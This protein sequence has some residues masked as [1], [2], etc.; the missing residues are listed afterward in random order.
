MKN[1]LSSL[2]AC[3]VLGSMGASRGNSQ[4]MPGSSMA[5]TN[6]NIA[7]PNS[8]AIVPATGAPAAGVPAGGVPATGRMPSAPVT[9]GNMPNTRA[10]IPPSGA[11]APGGSQTV[12]PSAR[13]PGPNSPYTNNGVSGNYG[14]L[15]P[16]GFYTPG[17]NGFYTPGTN[18]FYK[19]GTNG[20]YTPGTN[21]F[22]TPGTNG[23]YQ[24]P[25]GGNYLTTPTNG[26]GTSVRQ[27]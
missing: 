6:Q 21:G 16:N 23:F 7:V 20:F 22:Y 14:N 11:I 10:V 26:F 24:G 5:G 1:I 27:Q 18:G 15:G 4:T 9:G 8:R 17:T 12:I 3:F 13:R 25:N 2:I 19:P